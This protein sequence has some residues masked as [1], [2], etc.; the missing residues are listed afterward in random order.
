[1]FSNY[2]IRLRKA[3]KMTQREVA[4]LLN[5]TPQSISKWEK[6]EA[7]PSIEYLPKLAEMFHCGINAFFSEYELEIV[8]QFSPIDDGELTNL[9]LA[10]VAANREKD[11][12]VNE[13]SFYNTIPFESLFVPA[14]YEVLNQKQIISVG[15]LQRELKIGYELSAIIIDALR[16]MGIVENKDKHW[17][18]IK[19][20]ID[21]IKPYLER[22][23]RK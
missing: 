22:N 6:G 8:E 15:S 17:F 12:P 1:M 16:E 2:F 7:L 23:N 4:D 3:S 14:L 19:E 13:L 5:I 21:L 20:N 9:L 10:K 18:I 11:I